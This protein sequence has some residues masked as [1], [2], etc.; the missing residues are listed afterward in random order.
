VFKHTANACAPIMMDD[1]TASFG[2][3]QYTVKYSNFT[4]DDRL[5]NLMG[6]MNNAFPF[7][8]KPFSSERE[9]ATLHWA[10]ELNSAAATAKTWNL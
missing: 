2:D 7:N 4:L 9:N 8:F 5:L 3:M 6:E 1:R 10:F